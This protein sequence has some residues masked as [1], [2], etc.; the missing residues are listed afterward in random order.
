M[1]DAI[2]SFTE[3]RKLQV[4]EQTTVMYD[5]DLRFLCLYLDNPAVTEIKLDRIM[6]YLN[7]LADLGWDRNTLIP[8][9]IAMRRFFEFLKRQ[10]YK[11]I[12]KELIPIPEKT[13]RLPRV[14]SEETYQRLID[15]V[16]ARSNDP[17]HIRNAAIVRLL[18]DTGARNG[19]VLSIN[20]DDVD[21]ESRSAIIRT[22][23]SKGRRPFRQIF[24][25]EET[26]DHLKRWLK[27]RNRLVKL[28]PHLD[29]QALFVSV[30]GSRHRTSGRRFTIRG[31]GEM[32]RRYSE[33]SKLGYVN[34]HSFR[35]RKGHQIIHEG[36]SSTDVMNILGHSC[37]QSTMIYTMM[38]G[39]ELRDRAERFL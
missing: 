20:V 29:A 28:M 9:A 39:S 16:P 18:W 26:N 34:A 22:E 27:S 21:M 8:K 36:G 32:L 38:T 33:R 15:S 35:H 25:T 12:D 37:V 24:W 11:V 19:E 6:D 30:C 14:L 31:V 4:K 10:G 17:R 5:R 23:K 7:G 3:W 1:K 13:Y 2:A